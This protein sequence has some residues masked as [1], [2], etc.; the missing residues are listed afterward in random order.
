[1]ISERC[2]LLLRRLRLFRA[3]TVNLDL[4]FPRGEAPGLNRSSAPGAGVSLT[5][6]GLIPFQ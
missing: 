5:S 6:G 4:A 3:S 1:M 2:L